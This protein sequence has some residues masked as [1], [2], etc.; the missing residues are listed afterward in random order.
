MCAGYL[1]Q[2][3]APHLEANF[4]ILNPLSDFNQNVFAG[5]GN[6]IHASGPHPDGTFPSVSDPPELIQTMQGNGIYMDF[7]HPMATEELHDSDFMDQRASIKGT[8]HETER[9]NQVDKKTSSPRLAQPSTSAP[10]SGSSGEQS[11]GGPSARGTG[12]KKSMAERHSAIQE[13]NRRAQKRFRERQKAKLKDMT[14]QLDDMGAELSNLRMEN[15]SL[16][17]RN[18]VLEKVLTMRDEHIRS[19]QNDQD[20]F[21]VI[22]ARERC[23][24]A[25]TVR[26]PDGKLML[27]CREASDQQASA[28]LGHVSATDSLVLKGRGKIDYLTCRP[29]EIRSMSSEDIITRW[30]A[31]VHELGE[32]L[33]KIDDTCNVSTQEVKKEAIK[34]LH[35]VLDMGGRMCMHT[36]VLHPTNLQK[37]IAA[38][39]D[40]GRSG[41]S[42]ENKARWAS[43]TAELELTEEQKGQMIALRQMFV[44]RMGKV[45]EQRRKIL[46]ELRSL[47]VPQRLVALKHVMSETLKV[48]NSTMALKANLQEE[49]LCGL[50]FIGT[51]LKTIL[52]PI[53]KARAIV[54]SYPFYP[55]VFQIASVV[56]EEKGDVLLLT[57]VRPGIEGSGNVSRSL[58]TAA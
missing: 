15:N 12:T 4:S 28:A 24:R 10:T 39:F 40:D 45:L 21:E 41:I 52:T 54:Q 13:K 20:I 11:S 25:K 26:N 43:L 49:H 55:D 46:S 33:V 35:D 22:A 5:F 2:S 23:D 44:H 58:G 42:P 47:S 51:V 32:L 56:A 6:P 17:N 27:E 1:S 8:N 19:L 30:K 34:R 7:P 50:E 53:Q 18:S 37:L 9:P 36:A 14:E 38:T 16:K 57:T 48:N 29:E 3:T 31:M